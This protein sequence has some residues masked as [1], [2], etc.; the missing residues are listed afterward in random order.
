MSGLMKTA[1]VFVFGKKPSV[2]PNGDP[3][4]MESCEEQVDEVTFSSCV[5]SLVLGVEGF[6]DLTALL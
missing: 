4:V 3:C 5:T 6:W 1:G 2:C